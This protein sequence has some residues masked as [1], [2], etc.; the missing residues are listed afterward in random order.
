MPFSK[1]EFLAD[2]LKNV[3][4]GVAKAVKEAFSD[5][6]LSAN[7]GEQVMRQSE[8]SRQMD[9]MKTTREKAEAEV[10]TQKTSLDTEKARYRTW[11]EDAT[12]Q[13]SA[14]ETELA[15]YRKEFGELTDGGTKPTPA[16]TGLTREEHDKILAEEL[17]KRD[18]NA[19]A[20]ADLITDLK[21]EHRERF[22]EKLD[23][24]ELYAHVEKSGLPLEAAYKDMVAPRIEK[25]VEAKHAEQLKQARE[26]GRQ[27][28][29][30]SAHLPV[31]PEPSLVRSTFVEGSGTASTSDERVSAAVAAFTQ[32]QQHSASP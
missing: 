24:T 3:P 26:D 18:R 6:T 14:S 8:F 23:T 5:E 16:A 22:S 21:F 20:F 13:F 17:E 12:T 9:D 11:Y 2:V 15:A 27:D 1:D 31:S 30:S 25:A 19:M 10:L 4:E 32:S 7:I 29:L 28:A